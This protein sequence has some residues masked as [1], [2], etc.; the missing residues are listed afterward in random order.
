MDA[1]IDITFPFVPCQ[2]LSLDVEDIT[3]THI[4]N[5]EGQ[6][7][8]HVI[9]HEGKEVG[10]KSNGLAKEG[11]NDPKLLESAIKSME[12]K[13]GC[14]ME[15]TVKIH[16]VPGNFHISHHAYW[17]TMEQLY[18]RGKRID[19]T[20]KINNI[21]FGDKDTAKKMQRRFSEN[22]ESDLAGVEVKHT[23]KMQYGELSAYYHLDVSELEFR[24]TT[25]KYEK[26]DNKAIVNE[27]ETPVYQG[28]KFRVM[29]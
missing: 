9:D 11:D 28:Y 16:K 4:V 12:D 15:G 23:E 25:A 29:K 22:M 20:H 14:R 21:S 27:D 7:H 1:N 26:T 2:I 24:D 8:H 17:N 10:S 5:I 19:F 3:G 18:H 13:E 6:M